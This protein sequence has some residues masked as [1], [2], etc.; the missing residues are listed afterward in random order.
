[1]S[2]SNNCTF[3]MNEATKEFYYL[4]VC[5]FCFNRLMAQERQRLREQDEYFKRREQGKDG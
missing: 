5:Q 2:E 4:P 3:C 1:M